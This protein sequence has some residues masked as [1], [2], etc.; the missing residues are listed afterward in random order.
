MTKIRECFTHHLRIII[1]LIISF[2][3][4]FQIGYLTECL[5]LINDP[6]VR[7]LWGWLLHGI[8]IL[9]LVTTYIT[10]A[11]ALIT[12]CLLVLMTLIKG[13]KEFVTDLLKMFS[14]VKEPENIQNTPHNINV[15]VVLSLYKSESI[16]INNVMHLKKILRLQSIS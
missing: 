16:A 5:Y 1:I 12:T 13:I 15:I 8:E 14:K 9:S 6:F 4:S 10:I 7:N 2:L 3:F 11:T